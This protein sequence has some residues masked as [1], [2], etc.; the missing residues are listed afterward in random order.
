[1]SEA[2]VIIIWWQVAAVCAATLVVC[3]IALLLPTLFVKAIKP[4]KAIQFK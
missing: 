4:V 3:Y 2:P 1:V